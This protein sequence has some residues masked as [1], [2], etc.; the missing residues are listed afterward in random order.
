MTPFDDDELAR[1]L[2]RVPVGAYAPLGR[3]Q[4]RARQL[5]VRRRL[6]GTG[7]ALAAALAVAIPSALAFGDG[8]VFTPAPPAGGTP[9]PFP[10]EGFQ[11]ECPAT[12]GDRLD[13]IEPIETLVH[14]AGPDALPPS[15]R[16]LWDESAAPAPSTASGTDNSQETDAVGAAFAMCPASWDQSVLVVQSADGVIER[17]VHVAAVGDQ[18]LVGDERRELE[19]GSTRIRIDT[20]IGEQ[21]G[22]LLAEWDDAEGMTWRLTSSSMSDD[23]LVELVQTMVTEGDEI[24]LSGWSGAQ[25]AEQVIQHTGAGDRPATYVY[26]A[27]AEQAQLQLTVTDDNRTRWLDAGAGTREVDVAGVPG[28]LSEDAAGGWTLVWQPDPAS[29][30]MLNGVVD[31]EELLAIAATVGRV[32]SNDQRLVDAWTPRASQ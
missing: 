21:A 18:R 13:A 15:V 6:A 3:L 25:D 23:E 1:A 14:L 24:D 8:D 22:L 5:Q 30:A 19:A 11:T 31:P 27:F 28:L 7:I 29:T 17:T 32:P 4:G 2:A 16:L 26:T 20:E 12:Y 10:T 9:G